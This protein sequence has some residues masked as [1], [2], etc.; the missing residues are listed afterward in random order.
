MIVKM[1]KLTVFG[2][3]QDKDR[4]LNS[5]IRKQCVQFIDPEEALGELALSAKMGRPE[6]SEY[7]EKRDRYEA[8]LEELKPYAGKSGW[9]FK[10][11]HLSFDQLESAEV[12]DSAEARCREI[13]ALISELDALKQAKETALNQ[14]KLLV[15]WVSGN[16]PLEIKSTE[17]LEI[18]YY[19]LPP[20]TNKAELLQTLEAN[21]PASYIEYIREDKEHKYAVVINH[22]E[23][24]DITWEILEQFNAI[25]AYFSEAAEGP[26]K[27]NIADLEV[28]LLDYDAGIE[29][30][31]LQLKELSGDL[32]ALRQGCDALS[33]KIRL[34]EANEQIVLTKTAFGF[35]GWV[36]I[37]RKQEI[38]DILDG[39]FCDYKFEAAS[40][41]NDDDPPILFKNNILGQAS[42][43]VIQ[44]YSMPNYYGI[45]PNY[46]VAIFFSLFFGMMLS[47]A[48]YGLILLLGGLFVIK[49][50]DMSNNIKGIAKALMWGG[51]SAIFWGFFFGSLFGDIVTVVAKTFFN[52]DY[53][54]P[55]V[56]T[57]LN[58]PVTVLILSLALGFVHIVVGMGVKAYI[59][60]IRGHIWSAVFDVG[61]WYVVFLGIGLLFLGERFSSAGAYVAVFG[62]VGLILTQGRSKKGF[63]SKLI[64]GI[65]S[66]YNIIGYFSDVLSYSRILALALSTAVIASVFNTMGSMF[67]GNVL[68]ALLLL[69]VF[70]IGH[71]FNILISS[72]G[73]FVHTARLQYVEFFK[74]FY[75]GGGRPFLP[76]RLEPKYCYVID[77]INI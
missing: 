55:A 26:P 73:S 30:I 60:I 54:L 48:A 23:Y 61:F 75:E 71:A 28:K 10:R 42:E 70:L 38:A 8:V 53:A 3:I 19:V 13:E 40:Q 9:L 24:S 58:D 43:A 63:F 12:R 25:A 62:V 15:P 45:D 27:K 2:M 46:V 21:A 47:D 66:L 1:E 65:A 52:V 18:D 6:A 31:T 29:E 50:T 7:Q 41:A 35:S 5:L 36:P 4:M 20:D 76:Y 22:K 64:G 14:K 32:S 59:M 74:K 67:G 56:V 17:N 44:M 77:R 11:T 34:E 57:T 49:K 68:G 37:D 69:I 39:F 16:L 72:F 33:L 51:A